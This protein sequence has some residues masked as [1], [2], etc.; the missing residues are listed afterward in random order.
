MLS[1]RRR[2]RKRVVHERANKC[3]VVWWRLG[4]VVMALFKVVALLFSFVGHIARLPLS[5]IFRPHFSFAIAKVAF[6][7]ACVMLPFGPFSSCKTLL[8]KRGR[9]RLLFFFI[10]LS[11]RAMSVAGSLQAGGQSH[12]TGRSKWGLSKSLKY[13][14]SS[15][16]SNAWVAI[17]ALHLQDVQKKERAAPPIFLKQ[18]STN[19]PMSRVGGEGFQIFFSETKACKQ[20]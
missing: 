17:I 10:E 14:C 8:S 15:D 6:M 7:D 18:K 2:E 3:S 19:R 4:W 5:P 1:W 16:C 9:P 12:Q 20:R 11:P 13:P